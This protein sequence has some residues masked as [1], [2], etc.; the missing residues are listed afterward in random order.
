MEKLITYL[1]ENG[2]SQTQFAERIGI[3]QSSLSKMCAGVILPS[4][5]TANRISIE[6]GGHVSAESWTPDLV[7]KVS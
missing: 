3:T 6:T 7:K 5:E 2:V 4:L 1:K